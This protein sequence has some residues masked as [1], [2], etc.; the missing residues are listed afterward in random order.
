MC[1]KFAIPELDRAMPQGPP[2]EG[3]LE[4]IS[5]PPSSQ[6]GSAVVIPAGLDN[7]SHSHAVPLRICHR[8]TSRCAWQEQAGSFA[9]HLHAYL[10]TPPQPCLL[11]IFK[12]K[13]HYRSCEACYFL[14]SFSLLLYPRLPPHLRHS[15][16]CWETALSTGS[17][18]NSLSTSLSGPRLG[19]WAQGQ[20]CGCNNH[21]SRSHSG[22]GTNPATRCPSRRASASPPLCLCTSC[23]P[24]LQKP[25]R[26]SESGG[27]TPSTRS[28]LRIPGPGSLQSVG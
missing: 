11:A 28:P 7:Q 13:C 19:H 20:G 27:P 26:F 23:G 16:L 25:P 24:L 6:E 18:A 12:L 4:T 22:S 14:I 5:S 21:P 15:S 2:L 3:A 10:H 1:P 8:A 9:S 17:A